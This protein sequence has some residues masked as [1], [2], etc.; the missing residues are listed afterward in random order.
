M[1]VRNPT[2]ARNVGLSETESQRIWK[3]VNSRSSPSGQLP[4]SGEWFLQAD[5][6]RFQGA[7]ITLMYWKAKEALGETLALPHA[8]FY[9]ARLTAGEHKVERSKRREDPAYRESENNY[10]INYSRAYDLVKKMDLVQAG[11]PQ[12]L[13]IK[14]CKSCDRKYLSGPTE[15]GAKCP[16]CS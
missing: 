1:L 14:C 6:R 16:V 5:I 4:W 12:D 10:T 15:G 7:L 11:H 8:Y 3:R 2:V 13:V 9:F